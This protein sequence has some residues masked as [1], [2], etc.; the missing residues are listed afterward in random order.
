MGHDKIIYAH[1][2]SH[3]APTGKNPESSRGHVTFVATVHQ[4]SGSEHTINTSYFVMLDC[5][6]SEGESAFTPQFRAMVTPQV[7]LCR[8]LEAGTINT[9]LSQLQVICN[10]LRKKGKLAATVGNGLRRVLHPFIDTKTY[11]SVLFTLSP[12]VNNAK[13]TESTLKFAVAAGMVKVKPIATKGKV[14]FKTL[15]AELRAHIEKQEQVIDENNRAMENNMRFEIEQKK[16]GG[17]G[18]SNPNGDDDMKLPD[19]IQM[20][21]RK[22][23]AINDDGDEVSDEE[24]YFIDDSGKEVAPPTIIQTGGTGSGFEATVATPFDD[25]TSDA[26][27]QVLSGLDDTQAAF[28]KGLGTDFLEQMAEE[29]MS[30]DKGN[31][32]QKGRNRTVTMEENDEALRL[33]MEQYAKLTIPWQKEKLITQ[34]KKSLEKKKKKKEEEQKALEQEKRLVEIQEQIAK[35][36]EEY[37]NIKKKQEAVA[38]KLQDPNYVPEKEELEGHATT[39]SIMLA[40]QKAMTSALQQSKSIIIDFLK[41]DGREALVAFFKIKGGL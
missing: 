26:V 36:N 4:K 40:E 10:E 12:S 16:N 7:L 21:T 38:Q 22:I 14:N 29:S 34:T 13:S 6:G 33:A 35:S 17:G 24:E 30:S 28:M 20:K 37:N 8:R 27:Q 23:K 18:S 11:L 1:S 3:F 15:A 5:A 39:L 31:K 32:G 9:G 2:A 41:D 19:G 25:E